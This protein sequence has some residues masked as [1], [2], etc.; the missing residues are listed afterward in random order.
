MLTDFLSFDLDQGRENH[1]MAICDHRCAGRSC[2]LV[3]LVPPQRYHGL[4][5][6]SALPAASRD[7]E[8]VDSP[9]ARD[10]DDIRA[11]DPTNY[12]A[13][14]FVTQRL[15]QLHLDYLVRVSTEQ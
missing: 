5:R 12:G 11:A 10:D 7:I 14:S 9:D 6:P 1:G 8:F 15:K 3:Y 2:F 13:R 4:P